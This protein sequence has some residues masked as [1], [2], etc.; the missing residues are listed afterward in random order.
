MSRANTSGFKGLRSE[1]GSFT[2]ESSII[3]PLLLLFTIVLLF[4]GMVIY[5]KVF[6]QQKAQLITERAAYA[7]GNSYS[8]PVTGEYD[9][10]RH[11]GLYWRVRDDR[12]FD[13]FGSAV[14]I[15]PTTVR[16]PLKEG[17]TTLSLISS[18]LFSASK[19][20][21]ERISGAMTYT[22]Y[23][24][25]RKVEAELHQPIR[26]PDSVSFFIR[27]ESVGAAAASFVVDPT[28]LIRLTDLIRSYVGL[29]KG[30]ISAS[31]AREAFVEPATTQQGGNTDSIRSEREAASYVRA[32]V[33]GKEKVLKTP[34][35]NS[36]KIDAMDS[37]GIAHQAFYTFTE[38]QLRMEQMPRDTELLQTGTEV[39]G[40]VWHFFRK[41]ANKEAGPS[42]RLRK[43]LESR[44]IVVVIHE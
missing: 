44:G 33:G 30:R 10:L 13:L 36:R 5:Q 27:T 12:I 31:E 18:K 26:L 23:L 9:P 6:L 22:N 8:D 3:F 32:L 1:S 17:G 24:Y 39:K 20:L 42:P 15:P 14:S 37:N 43:D 38:R 25:S 41:N 35:G 28:E 16:L 40:V 7:W 11:D 29:I 2:I 4:L 19:L 34:S 21:P